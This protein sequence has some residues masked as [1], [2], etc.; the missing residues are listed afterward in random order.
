MV[1]T[2]AGENI[3]I[4]QSTLFRGVLQVGGRI[5]N[6]LG[7]PKGTISHSH[8]YIVLMFCKEMLDSKFYGKKNSLFSCLLWELGKFKKVPVHYLLAPSI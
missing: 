2:L 5:P 3:D 8:L 6:H 1:G 7:V 4:P